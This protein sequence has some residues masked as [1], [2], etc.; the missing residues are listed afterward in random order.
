[1]TPKELAEWLQKE[2]V[3][4]EELSNGLREQVATLPRRH[5]GRWLADLC[6]QFE[7]FRA[8]LQKHMAL[9][10]Y[11]GYLSAVLECRPTLS[12]RVSVLKHEH[13]EMGQLMTSIYQTLRAI[14]A[15][16]RLIMRDCCSRIRHLL[17]SVEEHETAENM[18]VTYVFTQDIGTQ[19]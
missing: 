12:G 14:T 19:D 5:L 7:C 10:E 4:V 2:H 18:M 6:A 13:L 15:D 17:D 8:H 3:Q 16:D 11:D 9:E 1:M